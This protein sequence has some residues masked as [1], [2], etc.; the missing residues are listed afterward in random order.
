M[1]RICVYAN[2]ALKK[3]SVDESINA[4][5]AKRVFFLI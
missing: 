5:M 1:K 3:V 2:F 4:N